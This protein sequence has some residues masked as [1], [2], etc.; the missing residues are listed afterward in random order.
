MLTMP[1]GLPNPLAPLRA[2]SDSL[3]GETIS[4][5]DLRLGFQDALRATQACSVSSQQPTGILLH[6]LHQEVQ[7]S[8]CIETAPEAPPAAVRAATTAPAARADT[9]TST[10]ITATT[11][12]ANPCSNNISRCPWKHGPCHV[13]T[14]GRGAW[15][16]A[17]HNNRAH[18]G[19]MRRNWTD[20]NSHAA[21]CRDSN[22]AVPNKPSA[23]ILNTKKKKRDRLV[24]LVWR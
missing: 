13:W 12:G 5:R 20:L 14:S 2:P 19:H 23:T 1:Q 7:H 3:N 4:V 11:R 10:P 17:C 24:Y 9:S 8:V 15:L 21:A 22:P 6:L 16:G 18:S